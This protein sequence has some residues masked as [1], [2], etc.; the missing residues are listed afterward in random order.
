M[1]II[2][3]AH[4]IRV[5]HSRKHHPSHFMKIQRF[6]AARLTLIVASA[7]ALHAPVA[8]AAQCALIPANVATLEGTERAE[9]LSEMKFAELEK[10]LT[11]QHKANMAAEGT[12]LLTLRDLLSVQQLSGN[13]ENQVR[14]WA[15]ERP[16]SFFAQLN[17]GIFYA[18]R[19]FGAR[20]TGTA[21]SV[22]SSQSRNMKQLSDVA[23]GYAQKAMALDARSA[24]PQNILLALAAATGQADGRTAEQWLQAAEQVDPKT[25]AARISAVNYLS[26]RW[27]GSWE[28]LDHMV[29]QANKA[30]PASSAHYL[31]YNVV[32]AKASHFEVIEKDKAKA[33]GLYQQARGM[34]DNSEAARSGIV[35]TYP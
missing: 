2:P 15:A 7:C 13:Q 23:T 29:A 18:N 19:A 6:P 16:Q 4:A 17:A 25:M 32:L 30:L 3:I 10:E 35:R 1:A 22:S 31:H 9:L 5:R 34:C 21:A 14:M 12:D 26:P 11:K 24:L 33:A 8:Q 20:G 27:G 28:Q